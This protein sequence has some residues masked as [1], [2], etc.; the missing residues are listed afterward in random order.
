MPARTFKMTKRTVSAG[1]MPRQGSARPTAHQQLDL[2]TYRSIFNSAYDAIAILDADGRY[3]HQNPA[4]QHLTGYSEA[5]LNGHTPATLVGEEAFS[6]IAEALGQADSFRGDI[7]IRRK[8]SSPLPVELFAFSMRD[9]EGKILC[10]VGVARDVSER[11]RAS[12]ELQAHLRHAEKALEH[13]ENRFRRAQRW[14]NIAAWEWDLDSNRLSWSEPLPV[15]LPLALN[16]KTMDDWFACVHPEDRAQVRQVFDQALRDRSEFEIHMRMLGEGGRTLWVATRGQ[17]LAE[18]G[19]PVQVAGIVMDITAHKQT[20]DLLQR[21]QKLAMIGRLTA[22]IA[23]EINNP[24][25]AV[26]NLL[27]LIEHQ[28]GLDA[29]ARGYARVASEELCRVAHISRQT[30]GF[31]R[32]SLQAVSID[33]ADLLDDVLRL[34]ARKLERKR[35]RVRREFRAGKSITVYANEIRQVVSNLLV[36]AIEASPNNSEITLRLSWG[37]DWARPDVRGVRLTVADQGHGI[38]R[39]NCSRVFEPFFTTK[40]ER[41]TGLGLWVSN[42]VVKKHGGTI[43]LRSTTQPERH[44][45]VFSVFLPAF[46]LATAA[47]P[48]P[49]EAGAAD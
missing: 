44:G 49:P 36:N 39:Q 1:E 22:S 41:G 20:E 47:E 27:Y 43:R 10:H 9:A 28:P 32:A 24:L 40:G 42:G 8:D 13:S 4:H 17:V 18:A 30:L 34:Y 3:L 38:E 11:K 5:D 45:T 35:I 33:M 25:E 21:S 2:E 15:L 7:L 48:V 31:Y 12:E 26:T 16:A 14:A 46:D 37:C 29:T 19:R 23:H 6:R